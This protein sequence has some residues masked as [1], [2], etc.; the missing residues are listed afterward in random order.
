LKDLKQDPVMVTYMAGSICMTG[1][2]MA[3]CGFPVLA[4]AL[5][6]GSGL[7]AAAAQRNKH[8]PDP[9]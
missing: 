8:T 7:I 2:L 3:F 5:V 6:I 9:Q 4:G 1:I